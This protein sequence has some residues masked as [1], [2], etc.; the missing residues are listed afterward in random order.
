MKVIV[1]AEGLK[2]MHRLESHPP[3]TLRLPS[4]KSGL[5]RANK[6]RLAHLPESPSLPKILPECTIQVRAPRI[7]VSELFEGRYRRNASHQE[8]LRGGP[9][10]GLNDS[11]DNFLLTSLPVGSYLGKA[12]SRKIEVAKRENSGEAAIAEIEARY[13]KVVETHRSNLQRRERIIKNLRAKKQTQDQMQNER[14][15]H[16]RALVEKNV[17][18]YLSNFRPEKSEMRRKDRVRKS[19]G[20]RYERVWSGTNV[21]TLSVPKLRRVKF[22]A[23]KEKDTPEVQMLDK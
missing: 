18:E 20:I 5:A 19:L 17:D 14:L 4:P 3:E 22:V 21:S 6:K 13:Q 1:T 11:R 8:L 9:G 10:M 15:E 16:I 12:M 2:V 23:I 7:R